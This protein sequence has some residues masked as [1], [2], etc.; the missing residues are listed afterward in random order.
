MPDAIKYKISYRESTSSMWTTLNVFTNSKTLTGLAANTNYLY[1][2][3]TH[4]P[5]GLTPVGPINSF[6]T[7][8]SRLA[9]QHDEIDN[10]EIYLFPNP[11]HGL[12]NIA[13][14]NTPPAKAGQSM[15]VTIEVF[16]MLGERIYHRDILAG[17]D[18]L[19]QVD[20]SNRAKGQYLVKVKTGKEVHVR[21]VS[22][23]H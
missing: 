12:F 13:I 7:A 4:C 6:T 5:A 10:L 9:Q 15:P 8:A 16:D 2:L 23:I 3:R 21:L 20:I 14:S 11:T 1:V 22:L 18:H 19:H 17:G